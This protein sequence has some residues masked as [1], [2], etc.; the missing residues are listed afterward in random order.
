MGSLCKIILTALIL[1]TLLYIPLQNCGG[2]SRCYG[3]PGVGAGQE[4]S[5]APSVSPSAPPQSAPRSTDVQ[6]L[7]SN[8]ESATSGVKDYTLIGYIRLDREVMVLDYRSVR[9][10]KVRVEALEGKLK[11]KAALY[12]PDTR[13]DS[14][15]V[16]AGMLR[17]WQ[18]IKKLKVENTPLVE[19]LLDTV[20][21]TLKTAPEVTLQGN[22]KC[23][24]KLGASMEVSMAG[25]GVSA[26]MPS[27]SPSVV[28]PAP[29]PSPAASSES[30]TPGETEMPS[31][32]P[33]ASSSP[34]L[35]PSPSPSPSASPESSPLSQW[36]QPRTVEKECFLVVMKSEDGFTDTVAIG[37]DD[38]WVF[39]IRRMKQDSM[40]FEAVFTDLKVNTSPKMN[41]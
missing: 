31:P 25:P 40:I 7:I 1:C 37:A 4:Q 16:K 41:L 38:Y 19:S 10:D 22:V 33:A 32:S 2:L 6:T 36:L 26:P 5:P 17:I 27:A 9:P 34:T 18:N 3:A 12:D 28:E 39:Y 23:T 13:K 30:P 35:S 15:K 8:M 29:S 11:G 24:A 20:I 14:I 21:R